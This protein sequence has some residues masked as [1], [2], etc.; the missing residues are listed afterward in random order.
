MSQCFVCASPIEEYTRRCAREATAFFGLLQY[1]S[2][3]DGDGELM[4]YICDSCLVE[5]C[6]RVHLVR[7]EG[8]VTESTGPWACPECREPTHHGECYACRAREIEHA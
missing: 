6:E 1:G 5:R 3:L 7:R 4:L 2:K 8:T